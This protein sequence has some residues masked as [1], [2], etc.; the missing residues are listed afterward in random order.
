MISTSTLSSSNLPTVNY[1]TTSSA[2]ATAKP[3]TPS[4]AHHSGRKDVGP[5]A[6]EPVVKSDKED[7]PDSS[8]D[9]SVISFEVAAH[10]SDH[11]SSAI[12][13]TPTFGPG[14]SEQI[15]LKVCSDVH[16]EKREGVHG[17]MVRQHDK[18]MWTPVY[19]RRRKR[20]PLSKFQMKKIPPH[21]RRLPPSSDSCSESDIPLTIPKHANVK[22]SVVDGIPGLI[23]ATRKTRTWTPVASR[24]R[25]R[26]RTSAN[27]S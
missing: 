26:T 6:T 27:N 21:C 8:E 14:D 18:Q 2:P 9:E 19:G 3:L 20:V 22:F 1:F 4:N 16:Y 13:T 17:V 23:I 25:A 5:T 10:E 7:A 24:T 12:P 11:P 15:D